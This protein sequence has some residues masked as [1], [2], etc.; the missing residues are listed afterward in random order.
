MSQPQDASVPDS[1]HL[2]SPHATPLSHAVH[3]TYERPRDHITF[4]QRLITDIL[5]GC[6][7]GIG[8]APF[9]TT[10]DKSIVEN[11]SGAN[12]MRNSIMTSV[13]EILTRPHRF[14]RRPEFLM[15]FGVYSCTYT[16]ANVIDS[17]CAR[18]EIPNDLP[19]FFGV[20]AL[21]MTLSVSKDRAYARLFG[22][23]APG[24]V[25]A[26]SLAV[27][28]LRDSLTILT[29]F[30]VPPHLAKYLSGNGYFETEQKAF[31]YATLLCPVLMQILST[32][33]HLYGFDRYNYAQS[34]A[35]DRVKRI[36]KTYPQSTA[37]RMGRI[38]PAYGVG[39]VGNVFLHDWIAS[40]FVKRN[41]A[42]A[43]VGV[44]VTQGNH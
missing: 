19:K 44:P 14:I 32:P 35:V 15:I 42:A 33:L 38:F 37:A 6:G 16:W 22:V 30:N 29:S 13:K 23:K 17:L 5:S 31:K 9:V 12:T 11:A 21:N 8:V 3:T 28:C 2:A 40:Q 34:A 25:P 18:S 41:Q 7:A 20:A 4:R 43:A 1:D 36:A 39:G 10:I 24:A 27:W 26:I